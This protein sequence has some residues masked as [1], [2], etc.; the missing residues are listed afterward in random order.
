MFINSL[1][2]NGNSLICNCT[3]SACWQFLCT[4]RIRKIQKIFKITGNRDT[5]KDNNYICNHYNYNHYEI[6]RAGK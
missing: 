2:C 4:I 6:L 5:K 3:T 1:I